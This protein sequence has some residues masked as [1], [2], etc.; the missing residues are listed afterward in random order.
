[1]N[2]HHDIASSAFSKSTLRKLAKAGIFIVSATWIPG[3]DGS[4]AN[5]ESAYLLSNGQMK[6]FLQ[7]LALA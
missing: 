1:M 7:V 5:G 4:Y 2:A 3:T 6:S